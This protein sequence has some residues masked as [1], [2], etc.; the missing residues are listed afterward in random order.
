MGLPLTTEN[1]EKAVRYILKN[2]TLDAM[3]FYEVNGGSSQTL[4]AKV[5][6]YASQQ[7]INNLLDVIYN[8]HIL[9]DGDLSRASFTYRSGFLEKLDADRKIKR[10]G[11][12]KTLIDMIAGAAITI[13]AEVIAKKCGWI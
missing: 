1:K 6:P 13:T 3:G 11:R 7:E 9:S 10:S 12:L 8:E 4:L 2:S 5:F